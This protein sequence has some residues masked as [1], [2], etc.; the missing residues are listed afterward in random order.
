MEA[1]FAIVDV[2]FV[3]KIG[4]SAVATVGLT[5]SMMSIVYAVAFGLAMPT[6]AMVARRIGEKDGPGASA[7]GAQGIWL[8]IAV[9]GVMAL[10]ALVAPWLLSWMGGDAQVVA[11]GSGYTRVS[12]LM[13]PVIVLLF[14]NGAVFRG[15]GDARRAM[16]AVWIANAINIAL[17]PCLIFGWG[18]FPERGVTGAAVAT[19]IGRSTGV[20]YQLAHLWRGPIIRI[21][22]APKFDRVIARQ[23]FRRSV[24]GTVQH[25]VETGSWIA[26]VRIV[27]VFGSGAIAAFTVTTRI[28]MFTLLPV[29]G[30]SNATATLV[31]QSLGAGNPERAER[32]VWLSGVF[33]SPF[34]AVATVVFMLWPDVLA[35]LMTQ[36]PEVRALASQGLFIVSF[37][38][39][40]Y[41]WQ[42]VT[43]QA[44]NGAGDTGTPARI[45]V[46]CFWFVQIPLAWVL[47]NSLQ[48]G[49]TGVFA[50]AAFCYSL[51]AVIG[52]V[53][54]KRG[55]WKHVSV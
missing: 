32:S 24:G 11:V 46:A 49:M 23:L 44:F 42:M 41:G 21:V 7:T 14:V 51:A 28:I 6:S 2:F 36:D 17:D 3:A 39:V 37:G 31:G 9:G 29:W 8:G 53:L 15:A 33:C 12:L 52:V 50:A 30:F 18:P 45:N 10:S 1:V 34:L 13:S 43:Q 55:T 27:A 26:L 20:A 54:V 5:E 48:M 35:G 16:R 22:D 38:Y 4:S 19:A 47:C 25:L 40:F